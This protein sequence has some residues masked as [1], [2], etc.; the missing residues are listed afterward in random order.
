MKNIII[1]TSPDGSISVSSQIIQT[2]VNES[3]LKVIGIYKKDQNFFERLLKNEN[4][5]TNTEQNNIILDIPV[6][7]IYGHNI[8][9]VCLETQKII[10]Y[11]LA[12]F[13]GL[14]PMN[15]LYWGRL[16]TINGTLDM[17]DMTHEVWLIDGELRVQL[18]ITSHEC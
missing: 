14:D 9:S 16:F 18:M 17:D 11:N 5:R 3:L 13:L 2:I 8:N 4:I 1:S 15:S 10:I 12:Q 6:K 7:V